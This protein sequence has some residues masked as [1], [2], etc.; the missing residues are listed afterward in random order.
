MTKLAHGVW[1][2]MLT[3]FGDDGSVDLDAVDVLTDWY[4]ANGVAG[5]FAVCLSSEMYELSDA[6][7]LMLARR[8]IRRAAGRVPVVA[9]GALGGS[10]AEQ[11]V[12]ARRMAETGVAAVVAV[13]NRFASA[14]ESDEV[15]QRRV[16]EF[17][18]L[19][20]GISL[21]LYECPLPYHRRLSPELLAWAASTGRFV[22]MKDTCC[23]VAVERAKIAACRGTPLLWL[24]AHAPSLLDSLDAGGGGY[25]GTAA[26]FFPHLY[27]WL[28][29][30]HGRRPAEARRLQSVLS[31]ADM[32]VRRR[33]P[34]SSKR[35]LGMLGLPVR[36][37][38]RTPIAAAV[39]NDD[40]TIVL[41]HLR[42]MVDA[43]GG[44]LAAM[45]DDPRTR[46]PRR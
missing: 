14:A 13:V 1:P 22:W 9:T 45:P 21:G 36:T 29:A 8:V 30:N 26:N 42:E 12:F 41:M 32:A 28:C 34:A 17:M 18:A 2:V 23:E 43:V 19:T 10:V 46:R 44:D 40:E 15:W 5:L 20:P 33:Y 6:E 31:V 24:N 35:Y 37:T 4:I 25:S 39:A 11:A 7:R 27:T 3:P 16:M 38:C